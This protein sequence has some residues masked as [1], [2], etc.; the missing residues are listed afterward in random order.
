MNPA[1]S[2]AIRRGVLGL[3]L[4]LAWVLVMRTLDTAPQALAPVSVSIT[5]AFAAGGPIPASST[6]GT[7]LQ[8]SGRGVSGNEPPGRATYWSSWEGSGDAVGSLT[9]GPFPAPRVLGLRVIG[10]PRLAGNRLVIE[11]LSTHEERE[12]VATNVGFRWCDVRLPLPASWVGRPIS[13]IAIDGSRGTYGWLGVGAPASVAPYA[14]LWTP[15]ARKVAAFLVS[16]L[17]LALLVGAASRVLPSWP[18]TAGACRPIAAFALVCL[19]G[20]SVFW[21]FFLSAELGRAVVALAVLGAWVAVSLPSRAAQADPDLACV[22]TGVA[23]IGLLYLGALLAFGALRPL[24]DLEATRFCDTL[25]VDNEL[26]GMFAD[27]LRL[28]EDPR[29]LAYGWWHSSDRPPLQC[30]LDLLVAY[31]CTVAGVDFETACESAG[32]WFQLMWVAA[33]WAWL[34]SRHLSAAV[35]LAVILSVALTGFLI[36]NSVYPWP[37]LLGAALV[38]GGWVMGQG[39]VGNR[40][41]S[42]RRFAVAGSL[43]ALGFLSHPGVAFSL[44]AL[45]PFAAWRCRSWRPWAAAAA[46]GVV[47]C[48]PWFVYQRAFDPPGNTL[49]KWH[50]AGVTTPDGRGFGEALRDAY[51]GQTLRGWLQGRVENAETLLRGATTAWWPS[52]APRRQA[53]REAEFFF[54]VPAMGLWNLGWIAFAALSVKRGMGAVP[55]ASLAWCALTVAVWV[56]AMILPGSTVLHQGSTVWVLVLLL[57]LASLLWTAS[58]LIF[59]SVALGNAV[60]FAVTWLPANPHR[61]G[62]FEPMAAVIAGAGVL[63]LGCGFRLARSIARPAS[64]A[65][66]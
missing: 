17:L 18:E 34:R 9:L 42:P 60:L 55:S 12:V 25:A 22:G 58:P 6:A 15:L 47:L 59:G 3:G 30:G 33:A 37:K 52:D 44:I 36:L 50:L 31:P 49:V 13:V 63:V 66:P 32:M 41:P 48:A 20:T 24:A 5:G 45:V 43:V 2:A 8:T 4:A 40:G 65:G 23:G 38:L 56:V 19:L 28:G 7:S 64:G 14:S 26:P 29:L 62:P 16:G 53:R 51:A 1:R 54:L 27:H 61:L 35:S 57:C 39:G 10:F 46:A 21:A 11:N